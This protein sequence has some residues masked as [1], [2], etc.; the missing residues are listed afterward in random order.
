MKEAD[1]RIN[2][3]LVIDEEGYVR[4]VGNNELDI[5][6]FP[7]HHEEWNAGNL[8]V[9]KYS[10]LSTLEETYL[11]SLQGWL[12]YLQTKRS[13]YVD[14]LGE[15]QDEQQLIAEIRKV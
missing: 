14:Y 7:V 1:D 4:I 10:N 12:S 5:H 8:Y 13:T 9:G 6:S 3:T 11:S 15:N 2:N